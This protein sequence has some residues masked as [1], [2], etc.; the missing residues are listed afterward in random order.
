[1]KFIF[2]FIRKNLRHR[3]SNY[4][5]PFISFILSGI[6]LCTS[7][8][9]LTLSTDEPPAEIYYYP[10]QISVKSTG[11][12]SDEAIEQAFAGNA[13]AQFAGTAE[14]VD[15]FPA[16]Q[17][18]I[19]T[20]DPQPITNNLFLASLTKDTEH[21]EFYQNFGYDISSLGEYDIA[22]ASSENR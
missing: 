8:F 1:M 17:K 5:L 20:F 14:Y 3:K 21:A 4:I 19:E 10:Y 7:V 11:E 6:L 16:Y 2:L 12:R 22:I 15:L 9:Y 18:E 13:Y